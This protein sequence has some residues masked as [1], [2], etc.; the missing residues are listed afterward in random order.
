MFTWPPGPGR[1]HYVP[2]SAYF[3]GG[4]DHVDFDHAVRV[5]ARFLARWADR[6]RAESLV[7]R[8]AGIREGRLSG[9]PP[10]RTRRIDEVLDWLASLHQDE[11]LTGR[12][13]LTMAALT[14][15]RGA[16]LLLSQGDG[17]PG[18]AALSQSE[19]AELQSEWRK[20]GLPDDLYV[21][22][23]TIKVIAEQTPYLGTT[24][25]EQRAYT[26]R[27]FTQR[28]REKGYFAEVPSEETRETQFA[29]ECERFHLAILRRVR[30]LS[31]PGKP[32]D[33][34][35]FDRLGLLSASVLDLIKRSNSNPSSR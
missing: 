33:V 5:T 25:I 23:T 31:E 20:A 26:P 16:H 6:Y 12:D 8:N 32:R 18:P 22:A 4:A 28:Q 30:E 34:A 29:A 24:V 3:S 21:P 1:Q 15:W 14:L 19:Y 10:E 9:R 35:A 17:A 2:E 7:D 11:P 27:A 13:L